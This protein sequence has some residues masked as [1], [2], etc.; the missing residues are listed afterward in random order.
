MTV[1]A[2]VGDGPRRCDWCTAEAT[3]I[4]NHER[5]NTGVVTVYWCEQHFADYRHVDGE[6]EAT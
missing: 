5:P 3:R 2:R 4:T 1:R 6:V